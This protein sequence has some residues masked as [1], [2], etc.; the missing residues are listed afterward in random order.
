MFLIIVI[1]EAKASVSFFRTKTT[2]EKGD[3]EKEG[4]GY[5]EG[6]RERGRTQHPQRQSQLAHG[7]LK[8]AVVATDPA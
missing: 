7:W 6:R 8:T 4:E 5:E 1:S 2:P 3:G